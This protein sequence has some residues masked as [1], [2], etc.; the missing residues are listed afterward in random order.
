MRDGTAYIPIGMYAVEMVR[1]WLNGMHRMN[2]TRSGRED[3]GRTKTHVWCR[4][5]LH[6]EQLRHGFCLRFGDPRP[7]KL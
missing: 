7:T 2:A 4:I 1:N 3:A 6:G 5:T